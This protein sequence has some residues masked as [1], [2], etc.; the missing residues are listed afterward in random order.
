MIERVAAVDDSSTMPQTCPWGAVGCGCQGTSCI[1]SAMMSCAGGRSM[2]EFSL[3]SWV[4]AAPPCV[5]G[6]CSCSSIIS[7]ILCIVFA[8][9]FSPFCTKKRSV[10]RSGASWLGRRR[11]LSRAG[12]CVAALLCQR[13]EGE[14]VGIGSLIDG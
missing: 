7:K 5:V 9:V 2:A 13:V 12:L 11:A 10:S 1:L 4:A 8:I 3:D 14:L 6:T